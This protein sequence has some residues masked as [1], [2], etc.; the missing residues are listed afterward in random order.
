MINDA[1]SATI[2]IF[3]LISAV[4]F[5]FGLKRLSSPATARSGNQIAAVAMGIALL[6]TLF[7]RSFRWHPINIAILI[8][9]RGTRRPGGRSISLARCR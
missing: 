8:V 9:G 4:I 5:I 3:Y 1:R 6:A 2:D 7:D